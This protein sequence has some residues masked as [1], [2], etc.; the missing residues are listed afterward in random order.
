MF[1]IFVKAQFLLLKEQVFSIFCNDWLMPISWVNITEGK[2][3][4]KMAQKHSDGKGK[5]VMGK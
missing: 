4:I 3:D 5:R 2:Q 1:S